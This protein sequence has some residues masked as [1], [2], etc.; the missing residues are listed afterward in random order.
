MSGA[1]PSKGRGSGLAALGTFAALCGGVAGYQIKGCESSPDD[2]SVSRSSDP[3][4]SPTLSD[5]EQVWLE[6]LRISRKEAAEFAAA[7]EEKERE[8]RGLVYK[9]EFEVRR[10]EG[11]SSLEYSWERLLDRE[12]ERFSGRLAELARTALFPRLRRL[13]QTADV[14][15][16]SNDLRD[17]LA[18]VASCVR[19]SKAGGEEF[20]KLIDRLAE[21]FEKEAVKRKNQGDEV[22]HSEYR[23]FINTLERIK[24]RTA[25]ELTDK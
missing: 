6:N 12:Q 4:S 14:L 1:Q 24:H 11:V 18:E 13:T 7:L 10:F 9:G 3:I 19:I 23:D 20:L 15:E 25:S 2:H 5:E 22:W 16:P 21:N 17:E 8:L